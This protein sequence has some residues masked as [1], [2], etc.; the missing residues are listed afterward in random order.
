VAA[1]LSKPAPPL[2]VPWFWSEQFDLKVH[3]AGLLIDADTVTVRRGAEAGRLAIFHTKQGRLVATEAVNATSDF[4]ASKR[5]IRDV[6]ALDLERL[7]DAAVPLD[8]VGVTPPGASTTRHAGPLDEVGVTPPAASTTRH[9]GPHDDAAVVPA[10]ADPGGKPGLPHATFILADGK[11]AS[12]D[13]AEGLTLMDASVRNNLPGII[14]ECGGMCSCGTC[15]VYVEDPWGE[16]LRAPEEDEQDM[17]EFIE[18]RQP[19]SRL[20][21]QIVMSDDLD[22]IIVRIPPSE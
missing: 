20:S 21:C 17:L 19:S 2:E 22:G 18:L 4:M 3:I 11:A 7:A 8:E 13:V 5:M 14:A 16:R 9:A 12:I 15:H 1:I 6:L 10:A